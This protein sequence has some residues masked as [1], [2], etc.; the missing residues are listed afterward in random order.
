MKEYT[1]VDKIISKAKDDLFPKVEEKVDELT[2]KIKGKN[3]VHQN[4]APLF[5]ED[6]Y[7]NQFD[8]KS[9]AQVY[10][11]KSVRLP[12]YSFDNP[13]SEHPKQI[14][15]NKKAEEFDNYE[16]WLDNYTA[17]VNQKS[18]ETANSPYFQRFT[19]DYFKKSNGDTSFFYPSDFAKE[20]EAYEAKI[21]KAAKNS[22]NMVVGVGESHTMSTIQ[23]IVNGNITDCESGV[24]SNDPADPTKNSVT[25]ANY[26]IAKTMTSKAAKATFFNGLSEEVKENLDMKGNSHKET[27][28]RD[29]EVEKRINTMKKQI[30]KDPLFQETMSME[31]VKIKDVYS[32]YKAKVNAEINRKI[33][34]NAVAEKTINKDKNYL[35]YQNYMTKKTNVIDEESM[36]EIQNVYKSLQ[37]YNKGK[38][39]SDEMKDLMNSLK[40]LAENND[41]SM[42]ALSILNKAAMKYYDK[43]QGLFFSPF[44]DNGKA[45]LDSVEKLVRITNPKMEGLRKE[46]FDQQKQK[47][48]QEPVKQAKNQV[49]PK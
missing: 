18:V 3:Y 27:Y 30:L 20:Y 24:F 42:E 11:L 22:E 6:S 33:K 12:D 49:K 5:G 38:K 21:E 14:Q 2:N 37:E 31:G 47:Q 10:A 1:E 28:Y 44:T 39:P 26:I 46:F 19:R 16:A 17:E 41:K 35:D 29:T 48:V 45:R 40:P 23:K 25:A 7:E 34:S 13:E 9:L 8:Y 32:T 36:K 15:A 4:M 43:R